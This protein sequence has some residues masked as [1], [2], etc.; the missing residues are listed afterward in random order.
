ML[1][2]S[3]YI[4]SY[5]HDV[6]SRIMEEFN[7]ERVRNP[8]HIV[9]ANAT[10]EE[11]VQH[12]YWYLID[13]RHNRRQHY[14]YELYSDL[15][16]GI[17][18]TGRR[19]AHVDIGCGA[20]LFSWVFL[21]WAKKN[22]LDNENIDLYGLDHCQEMINFARLVKD[23]LLSNIPDYPELHYTHDVSVVLN[24][25]TDSHRP[26]TDYT[27][28]FG[29]VLAQ[30]HSSNAILTFTE[31]IA[32]VVDLLDAQSNCFLLAVD[33][34]NWQ[35][36][37]TTGWDLMLRSLE[38]SGIGQNSYPVHETVRNDDNRAKIVELYT[39]G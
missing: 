8:G 21:D 9:P 17:G 15:L 3:P 13:S 24:E 12:T 37:F 28:T 25:L 23:D 18:P 29:H 22:G 4:K 33:A 5:Y 30:A 39:V 14:R 26:G 6:I 11:V 2:R 19:E 35:S 38:D 10:F 34:R 16:E 1:Y 7:I 32:Q 27:I 36:E 20:G 31:V